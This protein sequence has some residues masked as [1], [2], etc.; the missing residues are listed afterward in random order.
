ME[1]ERYRDLAHGTALALLGDHHLAEDAVQ[2]AF[3]E[4]HRSWESLR[5]PNKRAAWVRA[6][7]RHRCFRLLRRRDCAPLPDLASEEEPWQAAA[8]TEE[9]R[10]LLARV[11]ALP[12]P[13]REVVVLHYLRGCPHKEVAEFLDL[14]AT[15]VNNRLHLA[16]RL[17]KGETMQFD[18]PEVG[19]VVAVDPPL[20]DVRFEPDAQPDVFDALAGSESAPNLRVAQIRDDGVVRCLALDDSIPA[21]G[22]SVINR[23]P[24]G[25]TYLA[26]VASD[27]RLADAVAAFPASC[28]GM[29]ETGIKPIDLF[30]PLP[31]S[32]SVALFGTARTGK[33]VLT[34]ELV[35]RLSGRRPRLFYLADRSEPAVIRDIR[36]DEEE[37]DRD[38]VWLLTD[39]ATDPEFAEGNQLFDASIYCSP[40]LG[41]R[42]LWPAVDPFRSRSAV[43]VDARHA[44][45]AAAGR[46]LLRKAW[47]ETYDPVW[48][49]L[50]ACRAYA[51]AGRRLAAARD[52]DSATVARARLL[53]AFLT[54]PFEVARE[55]T[56]APGQHVPMADTLDGVEAILNGELDGRDPKTLS[57]IGAL[58]R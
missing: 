43:A 21:V 57:Y 1:L 47:A 28:E 52:P 39:R 7:V 15:T 30:C 41:M 23:T 8:R 40:L 5:D 36:L 4:A 31:E 18:T 34:Q 20:V 6:I 16:R 14:P 29:Q 44:R 22:R 54:T 3:V 42:H 32:G 33:M 53:E 51:A 48:F 37:F 26:P 2:D 17:L 50:L 10:D 56:G 27:A 19:T 49:E 46:E 25:G 45:L 12:K 55:M 24:L 11:R 38:V 13:L 35:R 58:D 9:R